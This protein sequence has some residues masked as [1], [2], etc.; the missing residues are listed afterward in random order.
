[1]LKRTENQCKLQPS[2]PQHRCLFEVI[3]ECSSC[4]LPWKSSQRAHVGEGGGGTPEPPLR[5]PGVSESVNGI[6]RGATPHPRNATGQYGG[7]LHTAQNPTGQRTALSLNRLSLCLSAPRCRHSNKSLAV[8]LVKQGPYQRFFKHSIHFF[9]TFSDKRH[10]LSIPPQASRMFSKM[11]L[12]WQVAHIDPL[13]PASLL[14]WPLNNKQSLLF[15]WIYT[16]VHRVTGYVLAVTDLH[17]LHNS[18]LI[19]WSA[20]VSDCCIH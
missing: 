16:I 11:V 4:P 6:I 2:R 1:M 9:L 19:R 7:K 12:K 20:W 15:I 14:V 5:T 18:G 8:F 17:R 13:C 3:W 10:I